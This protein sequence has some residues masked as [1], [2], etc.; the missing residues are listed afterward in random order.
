V[1]VLAKNLNI[2][3]VEWIHKSMST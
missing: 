2:F 3:M 1:A